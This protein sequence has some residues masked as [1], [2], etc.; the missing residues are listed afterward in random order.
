MKNKNKVE[1]VD[2]SDEKLLLSDVICSVCES[3]N[4]T[5]ITENTFRTQKTGCWTVLL[6][7]I[8]I[9]KINCNDC[10]SNVVIKHYT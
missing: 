6:E 3:D 5:I 2:N 8:R 7:N 1:N 10:N 9:L 4:I